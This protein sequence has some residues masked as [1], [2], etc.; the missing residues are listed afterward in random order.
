M[1]ATLSDGVLQLNSLPTD[2]STYWAMLY[3]GRV[4]YFLFI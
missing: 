3:Y 2:C 1:L 4:S